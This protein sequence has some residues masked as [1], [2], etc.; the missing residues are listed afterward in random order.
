MAASTIEPLRLMI[1]DRTC[2]GR[3]PLPGLSDAWRTGAALYRGLDRL[4]G[5][6]GVSSW[7]D[8]LDWLVSTA[9]AESRPIAQIQF[10]GHGRRGRAYVGDESFDRASL[11][12]SAPHAPRV[13]ALRELLAPGATVWFRTC[14]TLG[15]EAGHTF[16]RALGERLGVHVAGHTHVIG[17]WQSGLHRLAPGA[18]PHWSPNEG[19]TAEGEAA[20]ALGSSPLRPRTIHCLQNA[21]PEGW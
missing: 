8:A 6:R 19:V 5:A 20:V 7:S 21:I 4:D 12:E 2:V 9:T 1:H 13:T 17:F 15:G 16:A 3:G 11:D 18:L 14:E 10:W